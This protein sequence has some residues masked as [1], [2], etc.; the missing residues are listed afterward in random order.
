MGDGKREL[1]RELIVAI[2]KSLYRHIDLLAPKVGL[3][4]V[5][6]CDRAHLNIFF[7]IVR[8]VASPYMLGLA[9][10]AKRDD[11]L[12]GL[13]TAYL[14]PV[15][16]TVPVERVYQGFSAKR[17]LLIKRPTRFDFDYRENYGE[18]LRLTQGSPLGLT[19]KAAIGV[20]KPS[21]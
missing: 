13:M 16:H 1:D 9:T 10:A 19:L 8:K 6:H 15:L 3:L 12:T 2:D 11:G 7:K 14:G 18:M 4:V 5:D 21:R 20:K 17:P